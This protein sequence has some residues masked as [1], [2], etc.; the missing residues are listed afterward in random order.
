VWLRWHEEITR[1]IHSVA[2][3]EALGSYHYQKN[4]LTDGELQL[5]FNF[6]M[7]QRYGV[8]NLKQHWAAMLLSWTTAA[9]PGSFT[10]A[11]GYQK[12]APL[13]AYISC[14]V[15]VP[16]EISLKSSFGSDSLVETLTV[17]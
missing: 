11:Q 17:S 12:G 15:N 3:K 6:I 16:V 9:R 4:N 7:E 14:S 1:H 8:E 2:I 13:G 10:V 5:I